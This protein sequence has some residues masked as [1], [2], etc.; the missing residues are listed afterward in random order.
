MVPHFKA[1]RPVNATLQGQKGFAVP[2]FKARQTL[3]TIF[4]DKAALCMR[5]TDPPLMGWHMLSDTSVH[6][7]LL[8]A[9]DIG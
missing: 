2:D 8:H 5:M 4:Q 6:A 7:R 3:G 1:K 9:S